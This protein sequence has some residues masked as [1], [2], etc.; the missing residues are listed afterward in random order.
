[1]TPHLIWAFVVLCALGV[2]AWRE[3]RR[4]ARRSLVARVEKLETERG[5]VIALVSANK[6]MACRIDD[7]ADDLKPLKAA[8]ASEGI[9]K[10]GGR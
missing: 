7:L 10:L 8:H 5:E 9:R 4:D 3:W 1:M 6:K 2:V